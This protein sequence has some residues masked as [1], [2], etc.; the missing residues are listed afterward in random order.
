MMEPWDREP[1]ALGRAIFYLRGVTENGVVSRSAVKYYRWVIIS[2]FRANGDIN[3]LFSRD[4]FACYA[5]VPFRIKK[6]A[7][8]SD[9]FSLSL[10]GNVSFLHILIQSFENVSSALRYQNSFGNIVKEPG[11][12]RAIISL[13][14]LNRFL[15]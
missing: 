3:C 15:S 11:R 5:T 6:V 1:Y 12:T 10:D 2:G 9:L 14:P 7:K 4:V 13:K 8:H